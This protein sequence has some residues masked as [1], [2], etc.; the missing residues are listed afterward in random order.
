M[1]RITRD[2]LYMRTA[3]LMAQRSQ[4]QRGQVGC[5]IV[6]DKRIVSSGYNGPVYHHSCPD[7]CNLSTNC[8]ASVHAEANAIFFAA[9]HGVSLDGCTLYCTHLPCKNCAQAIVQ[10]GISEIVYK[11]EYCSHETEAIFKESGITLRRYE[12]SF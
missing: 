6:K 9:K 8:S 11:R 3:D 12:P 5:V 1:P 10:A 2:Q 4:C 7:D